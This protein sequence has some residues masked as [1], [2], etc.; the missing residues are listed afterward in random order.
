[1]P[2]NKPADNIKVMVYM[3]RRLHK[4]L[5]LTLARAELSNKSAFICAALEKALDGDKSNG[6]KNV[7]S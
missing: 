2:T 5:R 3:P 4:R 7:E 1:M 6:E